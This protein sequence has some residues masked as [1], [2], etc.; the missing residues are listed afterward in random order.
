ME[1]GID[2][3]IDKI[4]RN[5]AIAVSLNDMFPEVFVTTDYIYPFGINGNNNAGELKIELPQVAKDFVKV[6][7]SLR[8]IP[9]VRLCLPE[10]DFEISIPDEV[11]SRI[12]IDEVKALLVRNVSPSK[13]VIARERYKMFH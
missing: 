2:G 9:R 1:S 7:D 5:C 8:A 10:F 12:N 13:P 11:I 4:G 6:F 3:D